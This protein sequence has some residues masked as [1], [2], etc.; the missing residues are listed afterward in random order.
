M[1][2]GFHNRPIIRYQNVVFRDM[3]LAEL[4]T[5]IDEA[6]GD[7]YQPRSYLLSH[8]FRVFYI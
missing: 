1:D 3:V 5:G 2:Q 6:Y 4:W 7:Q 8:Y